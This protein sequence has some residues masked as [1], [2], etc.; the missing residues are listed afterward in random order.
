MNGKGSRRREGLQAR[1]DPVNIEKEDWLGRTS[2]FRTALR[3][4]HQF[5]GE[6][7]H[8][9]HPLRSPVLGKNGQALAHSLVGPAWEEHGLN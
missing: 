2:Y 7:W 6:P 8:K 9:D 1:S 5:N 4:F 3:K